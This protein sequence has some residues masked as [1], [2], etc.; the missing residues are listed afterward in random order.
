MR[1]AR[2]KIDAVDLSCPHCGE[3]LPAPGGSLFWVLAEVPP[4]GVVL[5]CLVCGKECTVPQS[6]KKGG[7]IT[8]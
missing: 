4:P 3:S 1:P 6:L 5:K 7:R 2:V 8:I